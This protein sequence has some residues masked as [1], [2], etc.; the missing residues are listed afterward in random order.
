MRRL[1]AG[2]VIT[3]AV[4]ATACTAASTGRR[5]STATSASQPPAASPT[6]TVSPAATSAA[7][8]SPA[9]SVTPSTSITPTTS[10]TPSVS[11]TR[12]ASTAEPGDGATA[13]AGISASVLPVDE[14]APAG[15]MVLEKTITGHLNEKS[16]VAS[17]TGLFFAQNM[18]YLHTINV[19]DRNYKLLKIIPDAVKLADF[20]YPQYPGIYKGAPVE[21][22]FTPDHKFAYV[23]NYSMYGAAPFTREGTDV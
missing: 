5:A 12:G 10:V 18:M 8:S 9:A 19:Y 4:L 13:K 11:S 3:P 14:I 21:A 23:S 6:V 17:G 15:R 2:L 20:G 7:S 1:L 22:A 16:V